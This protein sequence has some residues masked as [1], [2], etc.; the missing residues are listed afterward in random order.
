MSSVQVGPDDAVGEAQHE[1]LTMALEVVVIPVSDVDRALAFYDARLGWRLDADVTTGPDFR[2]VQL[3]PPGSRCS[4]IFGSGLT[5]AA[6]GSVQGLHLVVVDLDRARQE[7]LERG[8]EVGEPFHDAGGV[9]HHAD[10][11]ALVGGPDPE[12]RSYGSFA[13]FG[14]PDGNRWFLQEIQVRLPGR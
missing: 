8:V 11:A 1:T 4:I 6:P 9:F 7:L 14:D 2:V 13:A 5:A 12:G 3:T 10:G